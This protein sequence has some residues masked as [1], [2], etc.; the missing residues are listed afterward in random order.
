[1]VSWD[2]AVDRIKAGPPL[3]LDLQRARLPRFSSIPIVIL[4]APGAGKTRLWSELT[5]HSDPRRMSIATD[6]GYLVTRNKLKAAMCTVPGQ[7][8]R[9]RWHAL[10]ELFGPHSTV[11]GVIFVASFG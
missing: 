3:E 11:S 5:G 4:G 2:E 10:D 1:M 7:N 6:D 8:S 9:P